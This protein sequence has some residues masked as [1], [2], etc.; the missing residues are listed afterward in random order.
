MDFADPQA[1][2]G[3]ISDGGDVGFAGV[4]SLDQR[5]A[6]NHVFP[7]LR[8][9]LQVVQ[10]PAGAAVGPLPE[11]GLVDMLQVGEKQVDEG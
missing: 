4:E 10:H 8:Q 6:N 1:V 9:T 11:N 3:K 7:R 5:H 2:G